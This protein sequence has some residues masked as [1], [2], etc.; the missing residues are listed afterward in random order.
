VV[1]VVEYQQLAP[2]SLAWKDALAPVRAFVADPAQPC[3]PL[4]AALDRL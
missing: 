2:L 3:T 1:D 4:V